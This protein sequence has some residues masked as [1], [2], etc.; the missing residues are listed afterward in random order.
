MKKNLIF[1]IF[2]LV[3]FAV[4]TTAQTPDTKWYTSTEADTFLISTAEELAGLAQIVNDVENGYDFSG[5]TIVLVNDIDL[6]E[7][8]EWAP[9][10][11]IFSQ[12]ELYEMGIDPGED[13]QYEHLERPFS[14]IFDGNGKTVRGIG[15]SESDNINYGGLFGY[16]AKG[17][18]KNVGVENVYIS[19][20]GAVVG[21]LAD[22]EVSDCYSTGT[23]FRSG[24]GVVGEVGENCVVTRCY[25]TARVGYY[26]IGPM[27]GVV[28]SISGSA[29]VINCYSTGDVG[30]ERDSPRDGPFPNYVGGVVGLVS[31]DASTVAN[32]YSTGLVLGDHY[33]GGVV[34]AA[35]GGT[36][37]G[38]VAL[39][40]EIRATEYQDRLCGRV[41][42]RSGE[43]TYSENVAFRAMRGLF[44]YVKGAN[45]VNGA[46]ITIEEI[47]AD[48]TLDSLFTAEN[49]WT[50]EKGKLPGLLGKT[51]EIPE[52]LYDNSAILGDNREIPKHDS[53]TEVVV[54]A[55]VVPSDTL[56]GEFSIGPNPAGKQSGEVS[57]FYQG[58]RIKSGT[59][60][61]YDASGN[62]VKKIGVGDKSAGNTAKR[63]VASWNL[64]DNKGRKVS[65]GTY[66]VR[67]TLVAADGKK[68]TVSM[69]VGMR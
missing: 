65:N 5:K 52:H 48:S 33:I 38:C 19:G 11:R 37:T 57:F 53:G 30:H 44:P 36:V 61:V 66:L 55:P 64:K 46:D 59:L 56:T 1:V 17:V 47:L 60:T 31:G 34:G 58:K 26:G 50:T 54:V 9:I 23:I 40:P 21:I 24:G 68:E 18:V 2:I 41:A 6:S 20:G 14:G 32:C 16:V 25:S 22:G 29:R 3:T 13:G 69:F 7:W 51:V 62:F 8:D 42:G 15:S 45:T 67:G 39:N 35:G 43:G 28:G 4:F 49:G 63:V 27:G 12:M 10:G